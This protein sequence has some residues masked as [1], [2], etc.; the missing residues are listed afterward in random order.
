[1]D[2]ITVDIV[3]TGTGREAIINV[4]QKFVSSVDTCTDR[5]GVCSFYFLV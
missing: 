1:V 4:R 5:R 3:G 2:G